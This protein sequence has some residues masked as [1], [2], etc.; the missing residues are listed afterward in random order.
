M[1]VLQELRLNSLWR[2]EFKLSVFKG[3]VKYLGLR[4][5]TSETS[6]GRAQFLVQFRFNL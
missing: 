4:S 1:L 3:Y 5:E 2:F 6:E